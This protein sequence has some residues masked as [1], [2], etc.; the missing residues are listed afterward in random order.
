MPFLRLR[1]IDM[2]WHPFSIASGPSSLYLEFYIEVFDDKSWTAKLWDM[3]E[4][5]RAESREF[6]DEIALDI[7]LMG[8]FGTSLVRSEEFDQA[9]AVGTGTG[10][11]K[12]SLFGLIYIILVLTLLL[13]PCE[14][15]GIVPMISLFNK[16]AQ[17][18]MRLEPSVRQRE[19]EE[20]QVRVHQLERAESH[21]KGSISS[22]TFAFCR[23]LFCRSAGRLSS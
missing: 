17:Q 18:L 22:K 9:L 16:H 21:R 1:S 13:L 2:T 4:G 3:V 11:S 15:I 12:Q 14:S 5:R 8:P 7:E 23:Q 20:Q 6:Q 10:K 19:I